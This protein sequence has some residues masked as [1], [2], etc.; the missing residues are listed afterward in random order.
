MQDRFSLFCPNI[1]YDNF[2]AA[3]FFSAGSPGRIIFFCILIPAI[4][5]IFQPGSFFIHF[6]QTESYLS[7]VFFR[8]LSLQNF[9]YRDSSRILPSTEIVTTRNGT[10]FLLSLN[11]WAAALSIP[12]QHG[13][14]ILTT[15]TLLIRFC[16]RTALSFSV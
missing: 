6:C 13:T 2:P 10:A 7:P 9:S 5:C 4:S 14:S 8:Q 16:E 12:P 1:L 15:V 11:A 3:A